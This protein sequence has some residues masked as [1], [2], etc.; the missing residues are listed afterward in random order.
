[1][2]HNS[3]VSPYSH[4]FLGRPPWIYGRLNADPAYEQR[5]QHLTANHGA[6]S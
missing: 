2:L 4:E 5:S 6:Q 1:M 3:Y